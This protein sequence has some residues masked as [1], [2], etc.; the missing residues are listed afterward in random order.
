MHTLY[1]HLIQPEEVK[2]NFL[3]EFLLELS[4][5]GQNIEISET[6][7]GEVLQK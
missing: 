6:G 1:G 2:E 7:F 3:E 5:K 4:P